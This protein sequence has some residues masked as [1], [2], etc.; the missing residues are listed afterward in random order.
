MA[1]AKM[2]AGRECRCRP[3]APAAPLTLRS[4]TLPVGARFGGRV[5][6]RAPSHVWGRV[7]GFHQLGL[8]QGEAL[9]FSTDTLWCRV[10][11]RPRGSRGGRAQLCCSVTAK[12][13]FS[14]HLVHATHRHQHF[15][16]AGGAREGSPAAGGGWKRSGRCC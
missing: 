7:R 10:L 5:R 14:S 1:A 15:H 4:P 13:L 12:L 6:G 8:S 11:H 16:P 3:T 9:S 2:P